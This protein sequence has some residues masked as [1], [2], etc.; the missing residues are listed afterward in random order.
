M[1]YNVLCLYDLRI[2][3]SNL[4]RFVCICGVGGGLADL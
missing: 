3:P 2:T 1:A 4:S